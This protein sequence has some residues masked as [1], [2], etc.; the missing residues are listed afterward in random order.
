M[1]ENPPSLNLQDIVAN[2]KISAQTRILKFSRDWNAQLEQ[3]FQDHLSQLIDQ[4]EARVSTQM[5]EAAT[6]A[7]YRSRRAASEEFNQLLRH[8]RQCKSTEE[9]AAW[10]VDSTPSYCGQ[11]ALFEVMGTHVRGVGA[12][13]FRVADTKPFEE[14]ETSLDHAP[15]F[16]HAI[17]ECDTVIAIGAPSEVSPQI[18]AAL[19]HAPTEKVY[20]YP[21]VIQEK[22]AAILYATAGD[23]ETV[24]GAA[25]ELLAYAAACAVQIL[26]PEKSTTTTTVP[27]PAPELISID[28]VD[29][30]AH[31]GG[32]DSLFR[33]ALEARARWFARAEVARMRLFNRKAL[34]Q[35]R[36][37]RNIY[38]TLK[39]AIDSARRTYHQDF[40]AV[41]P[42]IVD[43][44]HR[45]LLVLAHD[46]ASLLG[47]EYPGSLV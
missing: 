9:V 30:N 37:Q 24:D 5:D 21:L 28:G 31:K 45:E 7:G 3:L 39:P 4:I 6:A 17:H 16:A 34:E 44:L 40:L 36:V 10:L 35:G 1:S 42:V 38:H 15:A 27:R 25:L 14:L 43:Y 8:L 23:R 13:G 29:M 41:S 19:A 22:A 47:P 2:Q 20:L 46:D 18:V 33:Q 32:S 12:R 11:A 26:A